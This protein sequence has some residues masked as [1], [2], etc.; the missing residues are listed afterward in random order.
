MRVYHIISS[1]QGTDF[2]VYQAMSRIP[3]VKAFW[4]EPKGDMSSIG[5]AD[6]TVTEEMVKALRPA[7]EPL[8]WKPE[9]LNQTHSVGW[10]GPVSEEQESLCDFMFMAFADNGM[11]MADFV[12]EPYMIHEE[13]ARA[14][15]SCK[16]ALNM[17]VEAM[18]MGNVALVHE[19]HAEAANLTSG[20][21]VLTYR[22]FPDAEDRIHSFLGHPD[23]RAAIGARARGW[24]LA[25]HTYVHR[26]LEILRTHTGKPWEVDM[27]KVLA[28]L[29]FEGRTWGT[30][31]HNPYRHIAV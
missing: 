6:I 21:Q 8:I 18:C 4:F 17:T 27:E 3:G 26:A 13:A 20:I 19:S 9:L 24:V 11:G 15:G 28:T 30:I 23:R 25:G 2:M 10:V 22:N 5:R 12:Y 31:Q 1:T 16:I 7:A 29:P 14:I